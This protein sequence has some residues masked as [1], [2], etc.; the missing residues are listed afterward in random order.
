MSTTTTTPPP[1]GAGL[2]RIRAAAVL[3]NLM[4]K[5]EGLS[6]RAR[7]TIRGYDHAIEIMAPTKPDADVV[8]AILGN[9]GAEVQ[10]SSVISESGTIH[11]DWETTLSG[12][13]LRVFWLEDAPPVPA[14][15][16]FNVL[17]LDDSTARALVVAE[18]AMDVMREQAQDRRASDPIPAAGAQDF[19]WAEVPLVAVPEGFRARLDQ[20]AA[21]DDADNETDRNQYLDH[22]AEEARLDA[23]DQDLA[24]AEDRPFGERAALHEEDDGPERCAHGYLEADCPDFGCPFTHQSPWPKR[25]PTTPE[26]PGYEGPETKLDAVPSG[27]WVASPGGCG[28]DDCAEVWVPTMGGSLVAEFYSARLGPQDDAG[29]FNAVFPV[30]VLD[31]TPQWKR[32]RG[33]LRL[34]DGERVVWEDTEVLE[35]IQ[36]AV[37][38]TREAVLAAEA[39]PSYSPTP[40]GVQA[41]LD[42]LRDL[43]RAGEESWPTATERVHVPGQR[44]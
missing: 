23:A 24:A 7:F 6:D 30:N 20:I 41:T 34:R 3:L 44:S 26:E 28:H 42:R 11:H 21:Q 36:D 10:Y 39:D 8:I 4:L 38:V 25:Q 32:E 1:V 5:L 9:A 18:K 14:P 33:I 43:A 37:R 17:I 27:V 13:G 40:D 22:L 35:G 19:Q 12:V 29:H 2:L 16:A 31:E 15:D